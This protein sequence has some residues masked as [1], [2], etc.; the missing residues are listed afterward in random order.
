VALRP[1]LFFGAAF[2]VGIAF[3]ALA[4]DLD[5]LAEGDFFA[6]DRPAVFVVDFVAV[7][8][9]AGRDRFV[10]VKNVRRDAN[11]NAESGATRAKSAERVRSGASSL[12]WSRDC[13]LTASGAARDVWE[14]LR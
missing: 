13:M 9:L 2:F 11:C 14:R 7:A 12:P 3:V 10:V 4:V 5:V 6:A 1:A 8:A